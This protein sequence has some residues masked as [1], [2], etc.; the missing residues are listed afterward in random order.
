[1]DNVDPVT[2]SVIALT[3]DLECVLRK[4]PITNEHMQFFIRLRGLM[5]ARR[6]M[7][8]QIP[9]KRRPTHYRCC[10]IR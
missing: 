4:P 3:I 8:Q 1:M 9:G 2:C 7:A 6:Y 5:P 10:R